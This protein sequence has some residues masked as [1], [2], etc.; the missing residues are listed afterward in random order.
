MK[1]QCPS[2]RWVQAIQSLSFME[3]SRSAN[4]LNKFG[5]L[6]RFIGVKL[7]LATLLLALP[8]HASPQDEI[9]AKVPAAKAILDA[10]QAKDP[11]RAE[12]MVH[13]VYW[14]P[15]DR[16]PA[17]RYRERLGAILENIRDFYA[18]EMKRLGFGPLTIRLDYA[19]DGQMK[20]HVVKGRQP[21]AKYDV[22][23]GSE[24]RNE[25]LT[26]LRVAGID[27]EKE[28]IVIFCN[29]S[30]WD[31]E[32]AVISQNSP[33]YAGGSNRQGTAWQVD[34]PILNLDSLAKKE[35]RV[36]DGQYGD[37]SIGRYNSIF[38][39]GIAHEL[40]HALGLPH[41]QERP[42]EQAAFGT[43][44][45]GSGNRSYGENLRGEG[46]GSF[47]TLAHGLKLAS[48]PI[49]CGSVKGIEQPAN[50]VLKDI[51]LT[52]QGSTFTFSGTVTADP[53]AYAVLGY[54]DPEGGG[55]Y[56]A[57]ICTAIPDASGKFRLQANALE[58]GKPGVFRVVVVQANGTAS[59]F[60]GATTPFTYPYLVAK[61]GTVDLSASQAR[62][63]LAPLIE[64]V[65]KRDVAAATSALAA[66]EAAK[67]TPTV[68]EAAKVRA[69]TLSATPA[70]SPVEETGNLCR[71]S[72][73]RPTAAKVGWERPAYNILPG[74][75]LLFSC[76]SR[77]FA[78]GIYA[79]A[80]AVHTW[81][82]GGK[83]KTLRGHAGL[84]DGNDSGSCVFAVKADGKELW[85]TK[86]TESGTLRSFDLKV[87]GVNTLEL[88]VEDAGDGKSSDWG[89]WFDPELSR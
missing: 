86:K 66:V 7:T 64:A 5:H 57:T 14:T 44:L 68:L 27:P 32:K 62:L 6:G 89:C 11:V 69:A 84:P 40:G 1:T 79:H 10:W 25:C 70:P 77:L 74:S 52:T 34:S 63:Q 12:K 26:T 30:N 38:I 4:C 17:P 3:N 18:R 46:K 53:P 47:L 24:I 16:E 29:M 51:S 13:I 50:A 87:E 41:N 28:T 88:V 35:P 39:G 58:P 2:D 49:F 37:I 71:L 59:S 22:Q 61:D 67:P 55:D 23:S 85:R 43:A 76:G 60:A 8:L 83:W 75:D 45:M 20:V 15:A 82:L 19:D 56:D 31:A 73:A 80:P 54:M 42:D 36:K 21:Y 33:Y 81:Q 9:S 48:H 72:D 78:R 65:G